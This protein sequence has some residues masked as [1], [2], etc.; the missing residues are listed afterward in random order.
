MLLDHTAQHTRTL[1]W[2]CLRDHYLHNMKQ[3][4]ETDIHVL[5]AFPTRDINNQAAAELRLIAHGVSDQ[6]RILYRLYN[7][8]P[9]QIS[10]IRLH[11]KRLINLP[12]LCRVSH[13]SVWNTCIAANT[14][15]TVVRITRKYFGQLL[16]FFKYFISPFSF[17]WLQIRILEPI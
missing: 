5:S 12:C 9:W 6:Y 17:N 4:Q 1:P 13:C 2:T 10:F 16:I 3:M 15:S 11:S 14:W 7:I 8:L